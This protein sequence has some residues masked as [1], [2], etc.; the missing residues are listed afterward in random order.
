MA[1]Y[2]GANAPGS[3]SPTDNSPDEPQAPAEPAS[4][5]ELRSR[6]YDGI[7]PNLHG[8]PFPPSDDGMQRYLMVLSRPSGGTD[9]ESDNSANA[10]AN[11]VAGASPTTLHGGEFRSRSRSPQRALRPLGGIRRAGTRI[12]RAMP[13]HPAFFPEM[14]DDTTRQDLHAAQNFLLRCATERGYVPLRRARLLAALRR[15]GR[16][17]GEESSNSEEENGSEGAGAATDA[18]GKGKGKS[19]DKKQGNKQGKG[20][21]AAADSGSESGEA[22]ASDNDGD[23]DS[24]YGTDPET[25]MT[26]AQVIAARNDADRAL[27]ARVEGVVLGYLARIAD[28]RPDLSASVDLSRRALLSGTSRED[29]SEDWADVLEYAG[30]TEEGTLFLVCLGSGL[31]PSVE[32]RFP[33]SS[34]ASSED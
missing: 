32:A 34:S 5:A 8:M 4:T 18:T 12:V 7:I 13:P 3:E 10:D 2:L 9:T 28:E 21:R 11:A 16:A 14:R 6:L 19:K 23:T 33:R 1:P 31:P 15:Q 24:D 25:G 29:P 30:E 27:W 22:S 20:A 17:A 26:R